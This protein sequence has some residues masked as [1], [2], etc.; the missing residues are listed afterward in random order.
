[1]IILMIDCET[2]SLSPKRGVAHQLGFY[3]V[4]PATGEVLLAEQFDL[5][6]RASQWDKATLEWATHQPALAN[7]LPSGLSPEE[8]EEQRARIEASAL[9]AVNWL[10]DYADRAG[11]PVAVVA[12][13]P[14]F[15]LPFYEDCGVDLRRLF[16]HQNIFDLT[17]L[18]V[19]FYAG[20]F[21]NTDTK[22]IMVGNQ[23]KIKGDHTALGDC[24]AQM[25]RLQT[26]NWGGLTAYYPAYT[27]PAPTLVSGAGLE[28]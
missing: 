9:K 20:R 22:K 26:A 17:S 3:A 11:C 12:Q 5:P 18:L 6:T 25:L 15:D 28:N 21:P 8:V 2:T 7:S 10:E 23:T 14:E 13:H 16:G 24:K 1:M 27:R 19:G 4:R